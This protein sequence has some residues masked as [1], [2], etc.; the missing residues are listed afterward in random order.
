MHRDRLRQLA[1]LLLAFAQPVTVGLAFGRGVDFE[2]ATRSDVGKPLIEPAGYAFIVWSLIYLG[3]MAY[4]VYQALPGQGEVALFRRIGWA[5]A[6]SF[7]AV[8]AWL[9]AARLGWIWLTVACIVWMLASLSVAFRELVRSADR[10]TFAR[11]LLV[12]FPFSVFFG[13]VSVAT[14]ANTA[15]ALKAAGLLDVGLS[16][17][18]WTVLMIAAAGAIGSVVTYRS[19]G[20]VGYGLT[21]VWALVAI[22]VADQGRGA[23]TLV[24]PAAA[25]MAGAVCAAL[26][27]GRLGVGR[28][29]PAGS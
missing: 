23:P 28:R 21:L 5:T 6:S 17:E 16:E 14:F 24:T 26:V 9:V 10:L 27:T 1:T 11:R 19:G 29:L 25:G 3:T 20:N 13:W 4:A 8:V 15:A 7:L 2:E 12:V 18:A 22:L